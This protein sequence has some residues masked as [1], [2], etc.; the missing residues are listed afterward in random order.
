[1]MVG[2]KSQLRNDAHSD[3]G[4]DSKH[5]NVAAIENILVRCSH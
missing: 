3:L 2:T 5:D 1:M 4:P